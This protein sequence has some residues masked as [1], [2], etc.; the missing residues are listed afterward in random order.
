MNVSLDLIIE[1]EEESNQSEKEMYRRKEDL[2]EN[3]S[4]KEF[5]KKEREK[6]RKSR[7]RRIIHTFL[8]KGQRKCKNIGKGPSQMRQRE[9]GVERE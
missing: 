8:E 9:I 6:E 1:R 5:D 4:Y 2:E 3:W 7:I